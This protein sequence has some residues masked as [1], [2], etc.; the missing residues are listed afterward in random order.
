MCC[1]SSSD[2]DEEEEE[3]DEC[4]DEEEDDEVETISY[5]LMKSVKFEN[6]FISTAVA[7]AR[8]YAGIKEKKLKNC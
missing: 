1:S 8:A 5:L 6:K 4:D 2:D 3:E 7:N